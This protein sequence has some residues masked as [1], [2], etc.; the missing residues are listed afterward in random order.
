MRIKVTGNLLN[1]LR[2]VFWGVALRQSAQ[3]YIILESMY[4]CAEFDFCRLLT[5]RRKLL[6]CPSESV[7]E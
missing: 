2:L 7:K 1:F 5:L 6:L 4:L 3:R